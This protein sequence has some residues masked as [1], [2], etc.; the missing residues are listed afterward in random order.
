M[1]GDNDTLADRI[2]RACK[3]HPIFAPLILLVAVITSIG[4]AVQGGKAIYEIV[5]KESGSASK[6]LEPSRFLDPS[7]TE[8]E[9]PPGTPIPVLR[10][11]PVYP[12]VPRSTPKVIQAPHPY[13][14][15]FGQWG[16][17]HREMGKVLNT[18]QKRT[19]GG[20]TIGLDRSGKLRATGTF[21][22]EEYSSDR[23]DD[24]TVEFAG[25]LNSELFP[26]KLP[27]DEPALRTSGQ[28][29]VSTISYYS[30]V[31]KHLE[32]SG[33]SGELFVYDGFL[34]LRMPGYSETQDDIC[35]SRQR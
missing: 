10:A 19:T 5:T 2:V 13:H 30:R 32:R 31:R 3:N 21:T 9:E 6:Q 17:S 14:N 26:V 33:A 20:I 35:F 11:E 22:V 29:A 34:I 12:V 27:N 1:T 4:G 15:W 24:S 28:F 8:E 16:T 25:S 23:S 7:P 18:R